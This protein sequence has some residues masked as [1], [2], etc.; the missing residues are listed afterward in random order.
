MLLCGGPLLLVALEA[1]APGGLPS[2]APLETALEKRSTWRAM[3]NSLESGLLSAVLATLIGAALALAIGLTDIQRKPALVFLILLPMM[4]PPHV[5]AIAWIQALGPSGAALQMFGIAPEIGATHPLYSREGIVLLLAVQHAPLVFLVL[6]ASLRAMPREMVEA[7]RVCGARPRGVLWRVLLPLTGPALIAGFALAFVSALG[8]FGIQALLGIPARYTTLP[9]LMWRRLSS[10]GPS[11]ISDMAVIALLVGAI[12]AVAV[13]LQLMLQR[14]SAA[15]L[16]GPPQPPLQLRLGQARLAVTAAIWGYLGLVLA[17]PFA[18]LVATGLVPTY[19]VP[20]TLETLTFR[21]FNVILFEQSVT[22]R[23]FANSAMIASSAAVLLAFNAVLLTHFLRQRVGS[24]SA[25]V[26][27]GVAEIAYAVPGLVISVAFILAF[28]R[29]LPLIG[30]SL[31]GS[32]TIILMA[33]LAAFLSIALKPV[34]AAREQLDPSLEDAARV[35]GAGFWMQMYRITGP[36]MA[37]AAASGAILVFLTAYNE[38]TVSALLWSAGNET[39]GTTIFNY[40]DGGYT[41]LA[42]AMATITVVA[43]AALMLAL[44]LFGRRLPNGVVPWRD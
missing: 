21:H 9:V 41:T 43:T 11:V 15:P 8:N 30:V 36:L 12:A 1:L 23:A 42:A 16:T 14:W 33:Y 26:A 6:R 17:L 32:L 10:Y 34:M 20:L 5:T 31:Y 38:V 35:S 27:I 40:E 44:S 19:G 29:P 39:I 25:S 22:A 3:W 18:S 13:T 4:I 28:L 7:A 2:L 37:P 24:R